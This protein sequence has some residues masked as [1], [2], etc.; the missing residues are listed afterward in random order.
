MVKQKMGGN[1]LYCNIYSIVNFK[2]KKKLP[3]FIYIKSSTNLDS[4]QIKDHIS[5]VE[6]LVFLRFEP[7]TLVKLEQLSCQ[8]IYA[9]VRKKKKKNYLITPQTLTLNFFNVILFFKISMTFLGKTVS[10]QENIKIC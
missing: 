8:L 10:F 7:N 9:L 1:L 5:V 4:S 3:F 6:R 2:R